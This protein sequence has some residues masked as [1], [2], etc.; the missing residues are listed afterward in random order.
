MKK[1][2]K[3]NKKKGVIELG[4]LKKAVKQS[5]ILKLVQF[6]SATL[7]IF[8]IILFFAT[9]G[10][11]TN[12]RA[13]SAKKTSI[14]DSV[15][16]VNL[17]STSLTRYARQYAMDGS[18][19]EYNSYVDA[20]NA[21]EDLAKEFDILKEGL[22][23]QEAYYVDSYIQLSSSL[24]VEEEQ[25]IA[26]AAKS[27]FDG[28]T[29][30]LYSTQY[31]KDV[32]EMYDLC[33]EVIKDISKRLN[34]E[35]N[36]ANK[37]LRISNTVSIICISLAA[38]MQFVSLIFVGS[39]LMR[40]VKQIAAE[41]FEIS[42]GN[43]SSPF[44]MKQDTSEIGMLA[45]SIH[46][47]KDFLKYMIGDISES[48]GKMAAGNYNFEVT[49]DYIGE[50]AEIK[51]SLNTILDSSND[52]LSQINSA[53]TQIAAGSNQVASGSQALSQGAT[54]QA[55]SI[56]ELSAVINDMSE[57]I[58]HI[59]QSTTEAN[60]VNEIAFN[61]LMQGN[62]QVQQMVNAMM[63]INDASTQISKIIKTID[64][65]AFQTNILALNAAVE[66][67]R[68]GAAGKGFSVVAEEVR[69]LASKSAEA[70]KTT[71]ELIETAIEAVQEGQEVADATA[72]SLELVVVNAQ[73]SLN[74]LN[75][76][77]KAANEQAESITQVTQ[78]VDQISGVVQTNSATAEESAAAS[79]ELSSQSQ[80]LKELVNRFELRDSIK[81]EAAEEE[82]S[83]GQE[84][85]DEDSVVELK[86]E[87]PQLEYQVVETESKY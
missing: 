74:S 60:N 68:A 16:Q 22:T 38:I 61:A 79:E 36:Q 65:I 87:E 80:I 48:L 69:N 25:A 62:E 58:R 31:S 82:S 85:T 19:I 75:E 7:M 52:M 77:A 27:D 35:L 21:W 20:L 41:M 23:K 26:L 8:A 67:A 86:Y 37:L 13:I 40:P 12:A 56:E 51:E 78:G 46:K 15:Y 72:S 54:E 3:H 2:E 6:T 43:L 29:E 39:K 63:K 14:V 4:R 11:N 34:I 45:H 81:Q 1:S 84:A 59:A 33:N 17:Q 30:I 71:T 5:T 24:R 32:N 70:A 47:T 50:F 42:Q 55:S 53:A 9:M 28:A 73:L 76:I 83:E 10:A 66:A 57:K 64:D 18:T 44:E 49:A